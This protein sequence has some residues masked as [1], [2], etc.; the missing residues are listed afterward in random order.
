MK[1]FRKWTSL[2]I[3]ASIASVIFIVYEINGGN[4]WEIVMLLAII[5][6]FLIAF[7]GFWSTVRK[8]GVKTEVDI[9][10]FLGKDAKDALDFG[11]IGLLTYDD[12]YVVTWASDF[13]KKRNIDIINKKATAWIRDIRHLFE[14]KV[15]SIIGRYQDSYYEII[16][17]DESN[18]LFVRDVTKYKKLSKIYEQNSIVVGLIQLDNYMEYQSYES[19]DMMALINTH[20]RVPVVQWAHD[21]GIL[22]RRLRSDRFF[23]VLNREIFKALQAE[24]FSILQL[25]KDEANKLD[26]SMSLSMAFAYGT[27]DFTKL[28]RMVN[29]L[30]ELAQSRGG[31]QVAFRNAKGSVRYI[32]GN[33]ESASSRSKVRVHTMAQTIQS[34]IKDAPK[35]FIAG[36]V[37]SDFDCMGAAL[38]VSAWVKSLGKPAYITLKNVPRDTQLQETM[39]HY[40]QT[41]LDRHTFVT[42][43]EAYE[44]MDFDNDLLIMVDHGVGA[45]SSAQKFEELCKN[46]I[47]IDHHRRGDHFVSNAKLAYVESGAGSACELIVELMQNTP[48]H[49][50]IYETEATI[51]Y[52]GILV[53]TN[54]FKI[55]TDSRTFEAAAALRSWGANSSM[56][57]QAL[58]VNFDEFR[59]KNHLISKAK[60]YG[61]FMVV[62]VDEPQDK[63]MLAKVAQS[64]TLVKGCQASFVI[65]PLKGKEKVTAVSA[66][67]LGRFNVQ[68][69][70][71]KLQGGGHFS[72]AAVE[73]NDLT[74]SECKTI[75]LEVLQK[76]DEQDEGN[77]A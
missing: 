38:G 68:K 60:Q 1:D 75:L 35:V 67:S 40:H 69:V 20:L 54:R 12:E 77:L 6:L 29:E 63:T 32:G 71:E 49:I 4:L 10:R 26:V 57:E 51:M 15:D 30:I 55:H 59:T 5:A 74:P 11:N 19:E 39:D 2:I 27:T 31:D 46:V 34:S 43:D 53:D 56:A 62:S 52:L 24:N 16:R 42:P 8:Q 18:V 23:L 44:M 7:Y 48:N 25:I 14:D 64:L 70:M 72:A 3:L 28:D 58:C 73:R 37:D 22:I 36:H 76:E 50:P 17:A 47:V 41:V 13:F 21:H 9:S 65:A 66:R 61:R 45:I 33:S